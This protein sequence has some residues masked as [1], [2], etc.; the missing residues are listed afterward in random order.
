[1]L[2]AERSSWEA[3]L[4]CQGSSSAGEKVSEVEAYRRFQ[5]ASLGLRCR[6]CYE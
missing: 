5:T 4:G 2:K 6:Y 3:E 1:M